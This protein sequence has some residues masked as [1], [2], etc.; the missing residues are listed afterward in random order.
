[1]ELGEP[2]SGRDEHTVGCGAAGR[3]A[4]PLGF[5]GPAAYVMLSTD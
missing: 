2:D 1:M 5:E 4:A 3:T